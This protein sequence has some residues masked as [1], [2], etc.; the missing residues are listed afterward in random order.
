M[1]PHDTQ[2]LPAFDRPGVQNAETQQF[3]AAPSAQGGYPLAGSGGP[4]ARARVVPV[5]ASAGAAQSVAV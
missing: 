4:G 3:P 5:V 1:Q 2:R